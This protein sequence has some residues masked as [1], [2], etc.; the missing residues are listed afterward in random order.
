MSEAGGGAGAGGGAEAVAGGGDSGVVRIIGEAAFL[1]VFKTLPPNCSLFFDD[2]AEKID[3]FHA[4]FE[5]DESGCIR[6]PFRTVL[7]PDTEVLVLYI[8]DETGKSVPTPIRTMKEYTEA[9]IKEL[10]MFPEFKVALEKPPSDRTRSPSP[11]PSSA[12][13][14]KKSQK[15]IGPGLTIPMI[16]SIIEFEGRTDIPEKSARLYFFDFDKL[17][18][19]RSSLSQRLLTMPNVPTYAKYLFSNYIGDEDPETG[20]FALLK[21][22]FQAITI[23]RIYIITSNQAANPMDNE[24][25]RKIF[26]ALLQQLLP[27]S[28]TWQSHVI[29]VKLDSPY[30]KMVVPKFKYDAICMVFRKLASSKGGAPVG[31]LKRHKIKNGSRITKRFRRSLRHKGTRRKFRK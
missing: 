11:P 27:E 12:Q 7:C 20:R 28:E 14:P 5:G 29:C 23:D 2:E 21:K 9:K 13:V 17:L 3:Q 19:Q 16:Q 25:S 31:R 8:R 6:K 30:S 15:E 18:T 10:D 26:I 22:M 4:S 1:E 24:A